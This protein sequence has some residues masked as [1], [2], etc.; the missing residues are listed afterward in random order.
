MHRR[1]S[2]Y[3]SLVLVLLV[4]LMLPAVALAST[5][6]SSL[7][8]AANGNY[9]GANRSYDGSNMHISCTTHSSGSGSYR[10]SLVRHKSFPNPDQTIG[11]VNMP[12]NGTG[13]GTWTSVGSGT[14]HFNF[15][16]NTSGSADI[17]C[18][19]NKVHMWSN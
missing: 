7:W 2:T 6:Y 16:N 15:N 8:V 4:A 1:R 12:R 17:Y 18:D 5:Y 13:S 14:Y 9:D 10:V 3:L 11:T 19:S